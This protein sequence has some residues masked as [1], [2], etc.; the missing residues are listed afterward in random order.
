MLFVTVIF[1]GFLLTEIFYSCNDIP[2]NKNII[3]S[4]DSS[5]LKLGHFLFFDR[6]LSVNN[7]RSCGTCH[8]PEFAFTDGYKRSL[9]A[10][11]DLHQRNTQPL[12]NLIYFKYF[13]AAD[14]TFRSPL[15]QMNKPLFNIHPVEMGFGLKGKEILKTI[16]KDTLYIQLFQN[17]FPGDSQPVSVLNIKKAINNY[18]LSLKS[19]N[20]PFDKF[21]KGDSNALS[22]EQKKGMQLF[23]SEKLSCSKCHNGPNFSS[24]SITNIYGDTLHYFN[25]GL[26]NVDG[27][28]AYPNYDQGLYQ[29]T[30]KPHDM[31]AFRVPTLRNLVFT[32]PYFHDGSEEKL[33]NVIDIFVAGGRNIKTREYAGIGVDNPLKHPSITGFVISDKE[34]SYLLKFL[35]ALSDSAILTNPA[36]Q[37]PF[38]ED[39]TKRNSNLHQ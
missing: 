38:N 6:R 21:T 34:K 8:N 36:Y 33:I 11:A 7:T 24:P 32:A 37:N 19:Q 35:M 13:T 17:S 9:G 15:D 1:S 12:F 25:I 14:S 30:K 31:G 20:S 23:Y 5:L 26:Y 18:I 28:G 4:A 10:F 2:S 29:L 22:P 16:S 3:I 27:K 39:E